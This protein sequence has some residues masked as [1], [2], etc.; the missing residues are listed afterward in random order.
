MCHKRSDK[1][2]L[3]HI[4]NIEEAYLH[5]IV[6]RLRFRTSRRERSYPLP[7]LKICNRKLSGF[8]LHINKPD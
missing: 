5:S 3:K 6:F 2:H 1:T 7:Q 4:L 8:V